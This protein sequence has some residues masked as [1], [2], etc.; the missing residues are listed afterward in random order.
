MASA[1]PVACC[2]VSERIRN[3]QNSL[4][5]KLPRGLPRGS[6][7]IIVDGIKLLRQAI[8]K[9]CRAAAIIAPMN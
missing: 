5:S 9:N 7:I 3:R 4:R 2:G 1:F 6:S 8:Q